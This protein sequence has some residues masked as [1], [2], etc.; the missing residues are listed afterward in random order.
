M[1]LKN[2]VSLRCGLYRRRMLRIHWTTNEEV[3]N[4]RPHLTTRIRITK[5]VQLQLTLKGKIKGK[6]GIAR[7]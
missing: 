3:T 6:R 7:K 4:A 1:P 5:T 2:W